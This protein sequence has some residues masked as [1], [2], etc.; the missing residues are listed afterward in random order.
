MKLTLKRDEIVFIAVILVS[1]SL[2]AVIV[3]GNISNVINP[4]SASGSRI[5]VKK[6]LKGIEKADLKPKEAKYYEVIGGEGR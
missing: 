5:D 6:V 2:I 3:G 4:L 1:L